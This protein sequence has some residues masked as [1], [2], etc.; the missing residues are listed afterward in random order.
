MNDKLIYNFSAEKNAWLIEKRGISFEQI[1]AV[2]E[3]KGAID[4]IEHPNMDQ[5]PHQKM[6]VVEMYNYVYLVPFVEE[7]DN[8]V[9]LKTVFPNRKATKQYLAK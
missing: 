7:G 4:V 1:I 8:K 3:S 2:L 6:Y 9:F 5:Y